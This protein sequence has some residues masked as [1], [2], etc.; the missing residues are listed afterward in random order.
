MPKNKTPI[1]PIVII[2][3]LIS[4]WNVKAA[5]GSDEPT[6]EFTVVQGDC[7]VRE[8]GEYFW[9]GP[10]EGQ[11]IYVG[12]RIRLR[13]G[14]VRID[15]PQF[16]FYMFEYAEIEVPVILIDDF[17][18]P[19]KNDL[20]LFIGSYTFDFRENAVSSP[21][22]LITQYGD[23]MVDNPARFSL[24]ISQ[25]GCEFSVLSG[26]VD[27]RLRNSISNKSTIIKTG[28]TAQMTLSDLFVTTKAIDRPNRISRTSQNIRN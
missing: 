13:N 23:I 4:T 21:I 22:K 8:V 24:E 20:E 6:I 27:V 15:F 17:A 2:L 14:E 3:L 1:L 9:R 18:E 28:Q 11:A 25:Q 16:T 7:L 12:D 19:W 26:K 10:E 5:Y